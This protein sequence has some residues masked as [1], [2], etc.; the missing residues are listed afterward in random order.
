MNHIKNL[1]EYIA[2]DEIYQKY[3][4]EGITPDMSD[5][6]KFCISHCKDIEVVLRAIDKVQK[7]IIK[8]MYGFGT[9]DGDFYC[10]ESGYDVRNLLEILEDIE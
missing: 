9:E 6:D 8:H 7:E 2:K 10:L 1:R 5:F 3:K 4:K